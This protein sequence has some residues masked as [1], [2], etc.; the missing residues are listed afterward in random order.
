MHKDF[1]TWSEQ[2]KKTQDES[3]RFYSVREI[4]WCKLG[5]NIGSEQDGK[6]DNF[7]RPCVIVRGFGADTCLVL[8]L[9]TSS[10]N[11]ALRVSVG[12]IEGKEAKANLSQLR[13]V[14]TRRLAEKIGFLEKEKFEILI[15]RVREL[16]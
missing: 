1:D 12:Q 10:K 8:P 6:G 3:S 7:L 13:L 14:D 2:K 15:K 9:T 5:V 4:W 16:F 11:H